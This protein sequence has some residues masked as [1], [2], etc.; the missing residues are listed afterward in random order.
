MV[1]APIEK[2]ADQGPFWNR[3]EPLSGRQIARADT[4]CAF[5]IEKAL[6]DCAASKPQKIELTRVYRLAVYAS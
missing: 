4:F 1:P 3:R 5:T 6:L 2:M